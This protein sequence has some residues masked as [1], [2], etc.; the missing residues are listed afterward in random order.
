M[1]KWIKPVIIALMGVLFA[2]CSVLPQ[3][4]ALGISVLTVTFLSKNFYFLF[5]GTVVGAITLG[6]GIFEILLNTLPYALA[7]PFFMLMKKRGT[8]SLFSKIFLALTVFILPAL[9]LEMQFFS[10]VTL[11]FTGLFSA[12]LIPLVKRLYLSYL[13]LEARL[14][15]EEA[16]VLALCVIGGI[17]VSSLPDL[18][19]WGF[20]LPVSALLFTSS[21]ALLAFGVKGSVWSTVSGI[22]FIIKGGDAIS[23]LCLIT[24]GVL[25]GLFS[26][27]RGGILLG[28]VLGDIMISLFMLNDFLV[29]LGEVNL[30]AG[31]LYTVFL[32]ESFIHRI[33]RLA[34]VES[35]VNDLEMNYI[36]GL[37]DKQKT[38]L[39][40][41]GRMYLELSKAFRSI[42]RGEDFSKE[43]VKQTL[44][45]CKECKK[46]EYCLKSRKSDT[47][48]ELKQASD[49]MIKNGYINSMPLTLTARCVQPIKLVIAMQEAYKKLDLLK[50]EN[51]T[52]EGEMALQLKS[53]SDMLFFLADEIS[54]LPQFDRETEKRARDILKARVGGVKQISCRK[55][56]EGHILSISLKENSRDIKARVIKALD[57]GYLGKYQCLSGGSDPKGGFFGVFAPV[58]KF[59]ID[60][61]A[62]REN[63][64][65]QTVCGD[66]FTFLDGENKYIAAISDGAGSGVRAKN[67]SESALELLEAFSLAD[68]PRS[69]AF[70]TMNRLLLL[71][72]EKED[73]STVDVTEFDLEN[74][75]MYWTKIGAVPGYILRQGKVERI[76]AGA[77]P[78]GIVTRID[79]ITTKKLV[80]DGDVIVLVSDGIYDGM[81]KGNEDGIYDMLIK[82]QK[83]STESI[84]R[85]IL[86]AAKNT[87]VDDD[88]TV[89]VL[90]VNAA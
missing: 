2:R 46:K 90:R 50:E 20:R 54:T 9:L 83:E 32:K 7:L 76:E 1:K 37:R 23:A 48:I 85:N 39:E 42:N 64:K 34:G 40:N 61:C 75:V 35:G 21:V 36:E 55:K 74:G 62:L 72:G 41:A 8:D 89:M 58:P 18:Q 47:L 11:I 27:K 63:K 71:K 79:P 24:G 78:M 10:R 57:E 15:L 30:L 81:V 86:S 12:C 17:T 88:M 28:F 80:L 16:D 3:M 84:A 38:T 68:I 73:Y 77:L 14:S 26:K 45:V 56:G 22:I 49:E 25:G 19:I 31:C 69:Q 43:I 51:P 60:V 67:E 53:I 33:K 52:S 44:E 4:Y 29:S 13:Q 6:G 70:K 65:G 82:N 5:V 87:A 66:S 59:N